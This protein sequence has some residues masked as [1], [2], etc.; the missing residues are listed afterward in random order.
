MGKNNLKDINC[1]F[2]IEME[3]VKK[4]WFVINPSSVQRA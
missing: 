4:N 2:E 1:G 3:G